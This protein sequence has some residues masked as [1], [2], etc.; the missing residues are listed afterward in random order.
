MPSYIASPPYRAPERGHAKEPLVR[1]RDTAPLALLAM[2]RAAGNAAVGRLLR[3]RQLARLAGPLPPASVASEVVAGG[4]GAA[5]LVEL[6]AVVPPIAAGTLVIF[7]IAAI[8]L[9]QAQQ[10]VE[11]ARARRD[12]TTRH[13]DDVVRQ[14]WQNGLITDEEWLNYQATGQ[15]PGVWDAEPSPERRKRGSNTRRFMTMALRHIAQQVQKDPHYILGF[16]VEWDVGPNGQPDWSTVRWRSRAHLSE[17]PTVQAGHLTSFHSGAEERLALEDSWFNQVSSQRGETQGAIFQKS[18]VL[19]GG[20]PV[21][22]RTAKMWESGRKWHPGTVDEAL[23][24]LGW[25][26]R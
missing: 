12:A 21:E 16:L 23:A 20:L 10:E 4:S 7:G 15:P 18:A 9:H 14:M 8:T 22:Y 24:S 3:A 2:Q 25:G 1:G 11:I 13:L 6:S 17:Q 26:A 5:P 19:L